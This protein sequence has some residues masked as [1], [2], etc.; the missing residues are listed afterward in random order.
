[1][2]SI[3]VQ[4]TKIPDATEKLSLCDETRESLRATMKDSA[5]HN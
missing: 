2:G 3:P 4:G 1:M 5:C